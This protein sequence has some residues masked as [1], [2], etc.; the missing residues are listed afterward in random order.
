MLCAI[1]TPNFVVFV[2]VF[3]TEKFFVRTS[4]ILYGRKC[5]RLF[6]SPNSPFFYEKKLHD[7]PPKRKRGA[8]AA[9]AAAKEE[10]K[11]APPSS[12]SPPAAKKSRK[13]STKS[14]DDEEDEKKKNEEDKLQSPTNENKGEEDDVARDD[15]DEKRRQ[16]RQQQQQQQRAKEEKVMK[17]CP[18]LSFVNRPL[19]D[20]DFE[21]RCSVSLIQENCYCC[22]TCGH[23]FAGRGPKTPAYT[24]SLER[25]NHHVFMRLENGRAFCLPENY[26]VFDKSLDD[27]RKVLFPRFTSEE[28]ASL[29]KEAMWSKAL[30]GSEFL[31]GVVGL[32]RVE[33][34]RGVN[35]IVQSLA[36]VEKLRARFL[37]SSSSSSLPGRDGGS[38]NNN[39][40][41]DTLQSLCQRIWNKHNFRGHTSPDAFVRKLRKQIKLANPEKLETDIDN[42][43]NDPFATL[44]HFLTFV[45]PKKYVD[46][47]F[48]GELLMLNQ[49]NKKQ[50]FV[51]VPLKL[52]DAPLFRDVMEKNAIPQV[53]LA[54]L[55]RP[56][57][58]KTAPEYLILA[59]VNRFSKNQFTKEVSKNPTIVT[60][61]V[62]NL[63][64]SSS[65]NSNSGTTT[66][67]SYDLLANVDSAG[68]ATVKHVDGNWYE[69]NDLLVNEVLA[70][71][72]TLGEAYVQIYKR[73]VV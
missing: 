38:S 57:A 18:Y 8:A 17:S 36:R 54:E 2:L 65:D 24:H 49:N 55:L 5:L 69:T 43:F 72:V 9:A 61:P 6:F 11:D 51:F 70:Q 46:E 52:P 16:Q 19:L 53:A 64:I 58:L 44:R 60:F 21:K 28:V 20:F 13:K 32:N 25:E 14:N 48:R 12:S 27:V 37:L 40:E 42:L 29:E 15:D 3:W 45:V 4:T 22:L 50:P 62:K 1:S 71:Q 31:V 30:D 68:K 67:V 23:F 56:F 41:N 73:V 39:N 63:K 66:T 7:M 33:N 59:F 26:E 47:L 34:A 35:P 10:N